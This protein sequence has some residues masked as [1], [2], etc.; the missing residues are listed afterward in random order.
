M[1]VY[2]ELVFIVNFLLDFIILYG[3]KRL[4]K[5]NKSNI[6]I[7]FGSLFG[8]LTTFLVFINIS[9]LELM[10]L[11]LVFSLIIICISF[12]F[13]NIFNNIMYFYL[14]SIIIGGVIYLFDL[15]GNLYFNYITMIVLSP[16]IT[17]IL[18][19]ELT[20]FKLNIN[21]KYIVEITISNKVYKFEGFIDTG[22][23]LCSPVRGDPVILVNLELDYRNALYIPYKALNNC[24][25]IPC[26][27]PDKVK[28]NDKVLS[29]YLVGLS[30]DRLDV[31]GMDCILPNRLKEDLWIDYL[32]F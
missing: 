10:I 27:R 22:N 15:N 2:I 23:R 7:F 30:K 21:D 29:N 4:L 8:S 13:K 25:V 3:T 32:S 14:I 16:I 1:K 11:K 6:R 31:N 12:G 20:K 19:K 17:K 18:I 28:I 24:G 5:I 9:N 26:I